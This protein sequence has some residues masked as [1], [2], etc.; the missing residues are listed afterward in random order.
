VGKINGAL[1]TVLM[2]ENFSPEFIINTGSAGGVGTDQKV[3]DLILSTTVFQHDINVT[4]F[5]YLPGQLP[6]LPQGFVA[7]T[8]AHTTLPKS[9]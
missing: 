5:G 9:F 8:S 1:S 4:A 6:G 2:I 3:G 7:E